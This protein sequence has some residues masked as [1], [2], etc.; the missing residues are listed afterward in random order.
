MKFDKYTLKSRIAPAFFSM[1]I[2]IMVFNHFYVSEEFSKFIG[3]VFFA[4]LISNLS[5]SVIC[6]Y[7]LSEVAR[8]ISKNVFEKIY[9]KDERNMPTTNFLMFKD[10][11]FSSDYKISVRKRILSDFQIN[12]ANVEEEK[13][14]EIDARR[15][16][17]ESMAQI[18]KK[19]MK[20]NFLFQHNVEYGAMRNAIG[21]AVIG[22]LLSA[23]NMVFFSQYIKV[24]LAV[25]VSAITFLVYFLLIVLSKIIIDF[26]GKNYAKILFREY[27]GGRKTKG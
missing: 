5:I 2:P 26:Y 4:K 9:F 19:L 14:D 22:L 13:A 17:V 7:Y 10:D 3:E 25:L 12:L 27:M 6:L 1:I 20:N 18:R 16:I 24:G 11:T 15:K 21:G 8:I 23:F